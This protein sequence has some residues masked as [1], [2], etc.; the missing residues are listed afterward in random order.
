MDVY[1][2]ILSLSKND[3]LRRLRQFKERKNHFVELVEIEFKMRIRL[4]KE[5]VLIILSQRHTMLFSCW[6]AS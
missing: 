4:N 1:N 6:I 3:D 2:Y 5:T